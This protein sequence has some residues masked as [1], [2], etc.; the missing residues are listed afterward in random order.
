MNRK[1]FIT[2]ILS[3]VISLTTAGC[4][5]QKQTNTAPDTIGQTDMNKTITFG[6]IADVQ[7]ADKDTIGNRHYRT[8][9]D[10]LTECVN[11]LNTQQLDFTIQLG[12]IIEGGPNAEQE[13]ERVLAIY[14]RLN[15]KKYHVL[16]NHDF[17]EISRQTVLSKMNI[18]Q[19]YYD[20]TIGSWRFIVLDTMDI[21]TNGGWPIDSDN[22][23]KGEEMLNRL[24][25]NGA[26]NAVDW[27]G[28]IS[29]DQLT[30]L[31]QTLTD[32]DNKNQHAIIFAHNPVLPVGDIHNAWNAERIV[33]VLE[34]HNSP[35]A[36]INGHNHHGNFT[37]QNNIAHITLKA[38]VEAPSQ[39]A[40][41]VVEL[42]PNAIIIT[43]QGKVT[44]R[45]IPLK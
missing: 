27:N 17:T 7:Y 41:A 42:T 36:Y 18:D 34:S 22:Y 16:G 31:D 25:Q 9:I 30:W 45:T 40:Y 26:P 13:L 5:D 11:D 39:N 43:G 4:N 32:A 23:R 35:A 15:T 14:N 37:R 21:A 28:G 29:D 8:S 19:S 2:L 20:F 10:K 38:M 44:S 3:I 6:L 33:T 1:I 12:D 24:I